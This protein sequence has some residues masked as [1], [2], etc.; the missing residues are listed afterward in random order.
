MMTRRFLPAIRGV[1]VHMLRRNGVG[2]PTIARMVGVTQAAVSQILRKDER[3][4]LNALERMGVQRNEALL[5]AEVLCKSLAENPAQATAVLY[6]FWRGLLSEG[7]LCAFHRSMYSQLAGCDICM[8]PS[9]E[10]VLDEEK[11]TVLRSLDKCVRRLE[12]SPLFEKLIPEVGC[13]IVFCLKKA[14]TVNDV[15]GVAG[16]I[17]VVN[18]RVKSVGRPSFGGS[19]HLASVLLR[20]RNHD[21]SVRSAIDIRNNEEVKKVLKDMGLAFGEVEPRM[22][23]L[24]EEEVLQDVEDCFRGRAVEAVLH[25]G[26]IGY[27]PVTYLFAKNPEEL[28]DRVL[29]IS[30]RILRV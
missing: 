16:R 30:S 29:K 23:V 26:G 25:G 10:R 17:V 1:V 13:N 3:S 15:A 24:T 14:E 12:A 22:K 19:H 11:I 9:L 21:R 20:V 7:R 2:Q 6:S 18:G 27:E 28:V 8:S 5:V 4:F